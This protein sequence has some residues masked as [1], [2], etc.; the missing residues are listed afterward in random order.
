MSG[1]A[2]FSNTIILITRNGMGSGE[3]ELQHD[4]FAKYLRL[5]IES[6]S[7]PAAMCFYTDGVRLVVE[8]SPFLER[9]TQIQEQTLVYAPKIIAIFVSLL[10]FLPLMGA[11]LGGFMREI[12]AR[13]AGM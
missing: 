7:L 2:S 4:L 13:I 10:V 3:T 11:M 1:N 6:G 12:A 9:L 5:L 8:G